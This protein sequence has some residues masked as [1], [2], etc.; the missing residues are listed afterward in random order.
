[1]TPHGEYVVAVLTGQN[2]DYKQAKNFIER[3][4]ATSYKYMKMDSDLARA[5]GAGAALR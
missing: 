5:D 3:L 4:A 2:S 1:M